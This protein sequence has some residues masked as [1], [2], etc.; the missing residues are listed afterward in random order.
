MNRRAQTALL[1]AL[2]LTGPPGAAQT[3]PEQTAPPGKSTP[4]NAS[5]D[6][7][8]PADPAASDSTLSL[9]IYNGVNSPGPLPYR[10]RQADDPAYA[11]DVSA[12]MTRCDDGRLVIAALLI[13]GHLTPLDNRCSTG[14]G[15]TPKVKKPECDART[16][17]CAPGP[18]E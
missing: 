15:S 10:P 7:P 18:A 17:N 16:W 8:P 6:R 3:A 1:T 14:S 4:W 11:V 12:I 5:T 2:L 13:G 9:R